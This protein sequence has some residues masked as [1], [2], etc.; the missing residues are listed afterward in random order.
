M[1][2]SLP[3]LLATIAGNLFELKQV[4]GLRLLDV[5]LPH[6]FAEAYDGPKFGIAGTRRL[7]GVEGAAIDRHDHQAQRRLW[8]TGNR[9]CRRDAVRAGID[10]IKDDELQAT[11]RTAPSTSAPAR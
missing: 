11:V 7:A 5:R 9:R 10:F 1:G 3:N 6:T 8:P 2:P 4:S